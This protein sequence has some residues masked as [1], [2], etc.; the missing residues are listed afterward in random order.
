MGDDPIGVISS[1]HYSPTIDNPENKE[2]VRGYRERYKV[3]P[4]FYAAGGY[5]AAMLIDTA[6]TGF[7]G[8]LADKAQLMQ[9]L[10]AANIARS[11]R[12]AITL[13]EFG[14]P[15]CDVEV[16]KV[17]RKDGVLQNTI[18]KTYP[19][20]SQFW[21]YPPKKFLADPVYSRDFPPLRSGDK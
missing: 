7:K 2:F 9:A 6:L 5:M 15:V 17:E 21:T 12:G 10:R 16:R 14:N 11:P 19:Q 8:D 4:G 18:I 20:V 1:G 3:A 13:D